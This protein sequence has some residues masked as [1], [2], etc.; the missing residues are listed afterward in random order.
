MGERDLLVGACVAPSS[1]PAGKMALGSLSCAV[2][3]AVGALVLDASVLAGSTVV[4][5][6]VPALL[7]AVVP[8][9]VLRPLASDV[10]AAAGW[11]SGVPV[12]DWVWMAL[13][14]GVPPASTSHFSMA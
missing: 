13:F 7:A 11:A 5:A 14:M 1:I 8:A 9:G 6:V 4:A 10:V 3:A 12:R 2:D